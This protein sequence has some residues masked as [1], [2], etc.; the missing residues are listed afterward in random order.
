MSLEERN[1]LIFEEVRSAEPRNS[2]GNEYT[3]VTECDQERA[4]RGL[5][6]ETPTDGI[7]IYFPTH[8]PFFL[9]RT[10]MVTLPIPSHIERT[11]K[12]SP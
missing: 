5:E 6:S 4:S 11:V 8:K 1:C 10:C 7:Y 12:A 9:F 3:S 2:D